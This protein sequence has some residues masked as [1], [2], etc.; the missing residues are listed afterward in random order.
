MTL[1]ALQPP[2]GALR[3]L[4]LAIEPL[5]PGESVVTATCR[6]YYALRIGKRF[7]LERF[8]PGA[9]DWTTLQ[10]PG[11][12]RPTN[13]LFD[14]LQDMRVGECRLTD[15]LA[16]DGTSMWQF[17]P[18]FIWPDFY[19][20]TELFSL[21]KPLFDTLAPNSVRVEVPG[22]K[23]ASVWLGVVQA[24]AATTGAS[25]H[26][27]TP[28]R[29]HLGLR[30]LMRGPARRLGLTKLIGLGWDAY[31]RQG[32]RR[33][34]A[35]KP[36]TQGHKKLVFASFARHW[37]PNPEDRNTRYDEQ[38]FPLLPALR[39]A[40]WDS[41]VG[42]DCPYNAVSTTLATLADRIE[43][44]PRDLS[45]RSFFA[46][47]AD[48]DAPARKT[49][50][51]Q[52]KI[53]R[54]DVSFAA[55]FRYEGV[56]LWPALERTLEQAFAHL[57]PQCAQVRSIARHILVTER[58]AA[59][60]VTYETGHFQR[61]LVIEAARLGIPSVGL[62]HGMIYDN[63][64]D[65]MHRRITTDPGDRTGVFVVPSQTCVWGPLWKR[66]LTEQGDYPP[67]V[68][69]VTGHWRHER[70]LEMLA[71]LSAPEIRVSLGMAEADRIILILSGSQDVLGFVADCLNIVARLDGFRPL[72][73]LHPADD[74]VPIRA[75]LQDR[76]L[77]SK[78][79][80]E[81]R[82]LEVIKAAE[83][84]IS[85]PSTAV[86]ESLLL[87]RP[88]VL[89]NLQ[90]LAGWETFALSGACLEAR[91][92]EDLERQVGR[93]VKEDGLKQ[94]LREAGRRFIEDQFYRQDRGSAERVVAT[95]ERLL[96][97]RVPNDASA[98]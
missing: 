27:I 23:L 79:L 42:I 49:F 95:L 92:V 57:L 98:R 73:K 38:F 18:S 33:L 43:Q 4:C 54:H 6:V 31:L 26:V 45:W 83:V 56:T 41:F 17:L 52:W 44:A 53:L 70:T 35:S 29:R 61:A 58:P 72:I 10:S 93:L 34:P 81:G 36:S 11:D 69:T 67:E 74:P 40:G 32:I 48:A 96:P 24:L 91:R 88:V 78:T 13:R 14:R 22:D 89:A 66:T 7:R 25:V 21:L 8:R 77:P 62:M 64:Y 85:Q 47:Q 16:Y 15:F 97:G 3:T 76:G 2:A 60:M 37:V 82:L 5:A 86:S 90:N 59:L 9:S 30:G 94:Q 1:A 28:S 87:D 20:T 39:H 55:D 46:Y 51:R 65:Y 68:V 84:V 19:R 71:A 50:A 12:Y 63:H 75:L 80:V